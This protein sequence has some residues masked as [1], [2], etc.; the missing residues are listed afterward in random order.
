MRLPTR[1]G[2]PG[3]EVPPPRK[4]RCPGRTRTV[5]H[6]KSNKPQGADLDPTME[7]HRVPQ[8][9]TWLMIVDLREGVSCTVLTSS[10]SI[11]QNLPDKIGHVSEPQ[12]AL[13]KMG[14]SQNI[15]SQSRWG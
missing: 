8:H 2:F 11:F 4:P 13:R 12:F 7:R 5:G 15:T 3:L 14:T 10:V 6:S 1:P 9:M